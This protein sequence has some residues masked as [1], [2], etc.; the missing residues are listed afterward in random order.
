M[1]KSVDTLTEVAKAEGIWSEDNYSYPNY[2]LYTYT[3]DQIYGPKNAAR[4]REIQT[5]VD[6]YGIMR[7]AGGFE[8]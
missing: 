1:Q 5:R 6:P 8:I 3:G 2:A 4:L 7:L